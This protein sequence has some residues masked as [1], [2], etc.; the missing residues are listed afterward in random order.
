[1]KKI[2]LLRNRLHVYPLYPK[3][4]SPIF[5]PETVKR[6]GDTKVYQV[7]GVA[8]NITDVKAGDW[9]VWLAYG[10]GAEVLK[11]GSAIIKISEVQA[12]IQHQEHGEL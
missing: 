12:V 7:L 6:D 4:D 9:V 1:M 3:G 11:D 5:I 8:P 10:T 2:T